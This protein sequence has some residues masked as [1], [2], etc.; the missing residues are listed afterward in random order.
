MPWKTMTPMDQKILFIA[1]YLRGGHTITGL[2]QHY[3]ISRKTGYKWIHRYARKGIDGL[4]EQSRRPEH[5]PQQ[6]PYAMRK[7]IVELRQKHRGILG[8]KKLR[9]LL[10][11]RFPHEIIP[12]NTTIYHILKAEGLICP[13]RR[14]QQV[15]RYPQPFGPVRHPNDLWSTD[16]K[17]QFK[18][19]NGQWCYPLTI[20]DHHSRYLLGCQGLKGTGFTATQRVFVR[21]FR[22]YGL[23]QRIRS[24]NGVPFA[25]R[26]VGG[27]SRLSIWWIRLGIHPERIE[28]G[29]PQQNGRHE[30]M[31]RTLKQMTARPPA[32]SFK[33]QQSRFDQFGHHY[34]EERPHEGLKQQPPSTWYTASH[35][36]YPEKLPELVYPDYFEI[37]PVQGSGVVYFNNGQV[38][39]CHLLH[40]Q[41][42]GLEEVDDGVWDVYFGP[43]RLGGFDLRE[44]KHGAVPY[45]TLKV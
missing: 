38:Y 7:A 42:V 4:E 40:Q 45:W 5:S 13:K 28:P 10:A 6:T 8:P 12:S 1:D 27:L 11:R 29:K 33:N 34:N 24:D 2:C 18:L 9:I 23:P 17:G 22:E 16:F 3:G 36:E 26:A 19:N 35:R 25:S 21:L 43:M 15:P 37:R 20:M 41:L 30:R 14:R 44:A 39:I 32:G 31:H